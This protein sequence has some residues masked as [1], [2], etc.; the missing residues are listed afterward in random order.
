MY[1]FLYLSFFIV[2]NWCSCIEMMYTHTLSF[3]PLL[4]LPSEIMASQLPFT[5]YFL[6]HSN[7]YIHT[8]TRMHACIHTY[9]HTHTHTECFFSPFSGE[10]IS[11][12]DKCTTC[13]GEHTVKE[14]KTIEV[15]INRGMVNI[16]LTK[17]YLINKQT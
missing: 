1:S 2:I 13:N 5:F 9:I 12:A 10:S 4:L 17:I 11:E 6:L 14:S 3:I 7:I 16:F 8:Y 15:H